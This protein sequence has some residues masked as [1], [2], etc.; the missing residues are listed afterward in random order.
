MIE[1]EL[2]QCCE[3]S[4]FL[5]I[6]E[7]EECF[8][9]FDAL[10]ILTIEHA[11]ILALCFVLFVVLVLLENNLGF[12]LNFLKVDALLEQLIVALFSFRVFFCALLAEVTI[13]LA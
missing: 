10:L 9:I 12:D 13:A 3:N 6:D 11:S 8:Y 1:V 4:L 7:F 2:L 5:L